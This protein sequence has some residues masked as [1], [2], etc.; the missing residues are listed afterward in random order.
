MINQASDSP[1]CRTCPD[2]SPEGKG[3][4]TPQKIPGS[5]TPHARGATGRWRRAGI[6]A[7]LFLAACAAPREAAPDLPRLDPVAAQIFHADPRWLG[8]DA[9]VSVALGDDRILWLFG[10]SFVD[11]APP[12]RRDEA[13][14][15]RNTVA[16][17]T[18]ADPRD[19][20]MAFFWRRDAKGVPASF[21]PED[22]AEWFWPGGGIRLEDGM[23]A[24]FLQRIHAVTGGFGFATK[25]YAVMLIANPDEAPDAWRLRRV[26]GPALPFDALPGAAV[27]RDGPYVVALAVRQQGTHAGAFV[28]YDAAA[29]AKGDLTKAEWWAGDGR[30][31]VATAA[32]GTAGP[33][34]VI[35]DAGAESSLHW[36]ACARAFVHV[37]S[38]GF[39]ASDIGRREA[40]RLTGP[41]SAPEAVLRP[42]ESNGPAPFVYAGRAH[43]ALATPAGTEMLTYI[44]S[45]FK[46]DEI[47]SATGQAQLYWPRV[48]RVAA[49]A[50]K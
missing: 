25:G 12:Y 23:L 9:A 1:D 16:L 43:A 4:Y 2:L 31:W 34:F 11:L 28:R 3:G 21:F 19:A 29:L 20:R 30:G 44:A 48:A 50:C 14:F 6:G 36:D 40:A 27:L 22:G 18:G 32:L 45:S 41:W 10:D 49:P 46:P 33:A 8:G 17:E 26:D 39:G 47:I 37:A 5:I 42:P 24:I 38:Y 15:P 13:A 7:L 35:D